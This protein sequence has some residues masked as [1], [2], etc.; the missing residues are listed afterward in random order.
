MVMKFQTGD[1]RTGQ[2]KRGEGQKD[3]CE[4]V[5][6]NQVISTLLRTKMSSLGCVTSKLGSFGIFQ[7][8]ISRFNIEIR[9]R[10]RI[11]VWWIKVDR[12]CIKGPVCNN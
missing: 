3:V 5:G 12:G 9:V 2:R 7:R 6:M 4:R 8:G 1:K 11:R 10:L